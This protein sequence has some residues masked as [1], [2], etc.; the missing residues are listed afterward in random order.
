MDHAYRELADNPF[1]PGYLPRHHEL[2]GEL[3]GRWEYEVGGGERIRRR[4]GTVTP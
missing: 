3:R 1:P 4:E 2:K